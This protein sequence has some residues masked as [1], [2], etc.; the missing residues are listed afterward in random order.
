M[1][2]NKNDFADFTLTIG[3]DYLYIFGYP[4][5][6]DIGG[7]IYYISTKICDLSVYDIINIEC[8]GSTNNNATNKHIIQ[9]F[10]V[11]HVD[12]FDYYDSG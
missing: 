5:K 12:K 6:V 1:I 2:I 4:E 3:A 9:S 10:S 8:S 7:S 11:Q